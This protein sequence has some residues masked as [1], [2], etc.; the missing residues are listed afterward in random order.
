MQRYRKKLQD[1]AIAL[2]RDV[3]ELREEIQKLQLQCQ[4]LSSGVP[5]GTTALA[6]VA[7]YFRLFRYGLK[8]S[9][10]TND[11][12]SSTHVAPDTFVS[13]V[14]RDFLHAAVSPDVVGETGF[15]VERLI[16]D[17]RRLAL[18][19][20]D[21][22]TQLVRLDTGPGDSLTATAAV[23][24]VVTAKMLHFAFPH[25]VR[26]GDRGQWSQLAAT[27]LGQRFVLRGS[28]QFKWDSGTSRVKLVQTRADLLTPILRLL[29]D[30]ETISRVFDNALI[31]PEC[32]LAH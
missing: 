6:V 17:Y 29:G 16:E 9:A 28:I 13:S 7:E 8:G 5:T 15:G 2:E 32:K 11:P 1:H 19:L 12:G 18:Y 25:L 14:Q 20:P 24:I 10:P 21:S 4:A 26:D 23:A 30:L 22:D 3:G 27:L 31:T